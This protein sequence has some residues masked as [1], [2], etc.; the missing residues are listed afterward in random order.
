MCGVSERTW[1][2]TC[3]LIG[4]AISAALTRWIYLRYGGEVATVCL[5]WC[6]NTN[7]AS[8]IQSRRRASP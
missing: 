6:I 7:L 8:A 3:D 2:A 1:L 4:V 5:L